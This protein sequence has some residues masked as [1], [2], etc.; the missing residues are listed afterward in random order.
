MKGS[1]TRRG[2]T[3]W[4]LKFDLGRDEKGGRKI[5][6]HTV[7][8]KKA[9]A[10]EK[11]TALLNSH[12]KGAYVQPS[13]LTVADHVR[14]RVDQWEKSGSISPKTAERYRELVENQIVPHLGT[15]QVQK[16]R[17]M[18]LEEWH[19]TLRTSGRKDGKG[20]VTA[21]TI[22][23]AHKVLSKALKEAVKNDL[24]HKN[25][26]ALEG[27]P[28]VDSK[29]IT[30]ISAER[31]SALLEQIR[32]DEYAQAITALFTG[33]RRGELLAL[34]WANVDLD[35]LPALIRVREALEETKAAGL[36]VK[37]PKTKAGRR[38]ITLPD[39][40]VEALRGHRKRALELRMVLG[41]GKL[42]PD[43]LV[44]PDIEGDHVSPRAFSKRWG[45]KAESIGFGDVTFHAL[46]HTHASQ[47]IDA[48]VDVVTISK[49]LGH[50]SPTI[51]LTIYAHLFKKDDSKAAAAINA[52]LAG[53]LK[54]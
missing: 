7:R 9:D 54:P 5:A 16:L 8:G 42:P 20:G 46:R 10:Q 38:D 29:E 51:T 2:K 50:A 14:A 35:A 32:G 23:H 3:S 1:I 36:R 44:F 15:K 22:G 34:R 47:L 33:L 45:E 4:R 25:V 31:I 48:G 19:S 11:L 26:A 27:S 49:R 41:A 12:N 40:V 28:K 24:T 30:I 17:P 21:R 6:Y 52:A 53:S 43:A 13:T 18:D 39:I 37:A